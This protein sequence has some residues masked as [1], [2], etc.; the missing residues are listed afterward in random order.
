M[1]RLALL[2]GI[3]IEIAALDAALI[4]LKALH[5]SILLISSPIGKQNDAKIYN[6]MMLHLFNHF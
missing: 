5:E 3:E 4:S 2:Q 1:I 6:K